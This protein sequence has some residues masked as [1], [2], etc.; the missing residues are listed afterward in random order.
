M[1]GEVL[2]ST[3]ATLRPGLVYLLGH[4]PGGDC[5]NPLLPTIGR[6]L[7]A[8]PA[9]TLNSY[10][11]TSWSGRRAIAESPL[12]QRVVW[13][14]SRLGLDPRDV[15]ASN[16]VFPRSR[17]AATS[18]FD[19]FA[20]MCWPVHEWILGVVRPQMLIAY[21]NSEP[22]PYTYLARKYG[23]VTQVEYPSG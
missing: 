8:L 5:N 15:A 9:K 6:S 11:D 4:N 12:Q 20:D 14:L 2:Y 22:S 13:L 1:S 23:A 3:G 18:Q 19:R 21:G 16:L 10:L 17:D 7:D